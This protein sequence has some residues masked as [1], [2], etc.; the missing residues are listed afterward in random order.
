MSKNS[1]NNLTKEHGI[2]YA[3]VVYIIAILFVLGICFGLMC[4]EAWLAMALWNAIIPQVFITIGPI[5]F[6]QMFGLDLLLALILPGGI[7]SSAIKA[8]NKN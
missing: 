5:T 2:G 4:L 6:W 8:A 1:F 7:A 3:T